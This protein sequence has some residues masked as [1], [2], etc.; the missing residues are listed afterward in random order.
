ME[1][2]NDKYID[3]SGG[4]PPTDQEETRNKPLRAGSASDPAAISRERSHNFP[5]TP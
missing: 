4:L 5:I 3:I 1:L 2:D